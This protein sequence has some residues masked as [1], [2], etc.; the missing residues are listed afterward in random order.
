MIFLGVERVTTRDVGQISLE[1]S[2]GIINLIW[3]YGM[4]IGRKRRDP[5]GGVNH[6]KKTLESEIPKKRFRV[7]LFE[8]G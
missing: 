3:F 8:A 7:C 2:L 6:R 4:I 5:V 1:L